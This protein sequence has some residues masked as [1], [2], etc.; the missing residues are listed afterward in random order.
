MNHHSLGRQ[1]AIE[2]LRRYRILERIRPNVL[3]SP[4]Y[5][6]VFPFRTIIEH[7]GLRLNIDP[8]SHLGRLLLLNDSYEPQT[9]SL[10][11]EIISAGDTVLD[12]GANEGIFSALAA[13]LVGPTGCVISVE[14]QSRMQ[15]TLEI[16]L[17]LNA[18]CQTL[19][20]HNALD[21]TDGRHVEIELFPRSCTGA[22]SLVH[23]YR[24]GKRTEIVETITPLTLLRHSERGH[25]DFVKIDVEGYE[26][27]VVRSL[28]LDR[29]KNLLVDYHASILMDRGL[30]PE[31]TDALVR[32]THR[33]VQGSITGGYVFYRLVA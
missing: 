5:S 23:S 24:W 1:E 7:E 22:S 19:I 32:R 33:S 21:E 10:F 17:A 28:P 15:D 16:N 31:E 27:E 30:D 6:L 12:V 26:P 13:S 11:R 20:A 4:L 9:F 18:H 3:A 2:R 14:P 29:V 8:A 25:F